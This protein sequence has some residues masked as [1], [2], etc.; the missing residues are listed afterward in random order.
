MGESTK[1]L[2]LSVGSRIELGRQPTGSGLLPDRGGSER[3]QWGQSVHKREC[4][5]EQL[6]LDRALTGRQHVSLTVQSVDVVIA[7]L[8]DKLPTFVL[9][10]SSQRLQRVAGELLIKDEGLLIVGTNVIR[11]AKT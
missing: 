8:H 4:Q 6:T 5:K 3:I 2:A 11:V 10:T 7:P 1:R 9:P